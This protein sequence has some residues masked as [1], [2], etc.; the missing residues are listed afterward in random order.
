MRV[1]EHGAAVFVPE[2]QSSEQPAGGIARGAEEVG[3]AVRFAKAHA[4]EYGGDRERVII[5]GHSGGGSFGA[6]VALAGEQ[7]VGDC[8]VPAGDATPDMVIGL[9]GAY[10]LPRYVSP[11]TLGAAPAEEW[12][13]ITPYT[14]V[15]AGARRRGLTFHLFVGL[16][17]ELLQDAQAFRDVLQA[18]GYE[19]TLTQFPGI[20]HMRM[21]SDRHENT[22]WAI[23]TLMDE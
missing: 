6:L 4:A 3:C 12:Q 5:V 10:H 13:R 18:A 11:E 9:D 16:E 1:A 14:Y 17:Q 22:V 7:F 19:V 8:L 21:A 23:V 20:D 15:D 2:Y